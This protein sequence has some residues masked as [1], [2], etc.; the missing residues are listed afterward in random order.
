MHWIDSVFWWVGFTV[1]A[2]GSLGALAMIFA[3][4]FDYCWRR[5]GDI[6]TLFDVVKEARRQGRPIFK[7]RT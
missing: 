2:V 3:F 5:Y 1:C 6:I 7:D 4:P